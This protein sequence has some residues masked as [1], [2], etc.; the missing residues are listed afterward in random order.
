[1]K[2]HGE[3]GHLD[4]TGRVDWN[5]GL[6]QMVGAMVGMVGWSGCGS[7]RLECMVGLDNCGKRSRN[8][9]WMFRK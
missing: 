7:E 4:S 2:D 3:H 1:M 8:W 6:N 5:G 9:W